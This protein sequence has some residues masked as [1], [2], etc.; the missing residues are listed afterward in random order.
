MNQP[1]FICE[2][3]EGIGFKYETHP[4][5]D[6]Y[7]CECQRCGKYDI[8][9]Q[10]ARQ[11]AEDLALIGD[12]RLRVSAAIRDATD[13]E[14]RLTEP[15][16]DRNYRVLASTVAAPRDGLEQLD[17]LVDAIASRTH[18]FGEATRPDDVERWAA[19][20]FF[21][22]RTQFFSMVTVARSMRLVDMQSVSKD[23]RD[24]TF[25]LTIDGW[26]HAREVR[27]HRGNGRQAFVAMWFH[28]NLVSAYESGIAQALGDTGYSP[29]R[30][31]L[32]HHNN[33]IDDE[34]LGQLRRSRILVADATG[35][36]AN[37][38]YEAGFAYGLGLPVIW[39]CNESYKSF[40]PDDR[41]DL[42]AAPSVAQK[43]WLDRVAFDTRQHNF[44][45]WSSADELRTKLTARIRGLGL[46]LTA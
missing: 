27:R 46:D 17:M 13:H 6:A 42:T 22:N 21:R 41:P 37:V 25:A 9:C 8:D 3:P 14:R 11:D 39:C 18:T 32:A 29:Y 15:I 23:K 40:Q 31:D 7:L 1:C 19:R 44:I 5:A 26:R 28:P 43:S 30:V 12:E 33:R 38:Y 24:V 4:S 20:L 36:R 2:S 10:F 34:I 35:A 16:D 45:P